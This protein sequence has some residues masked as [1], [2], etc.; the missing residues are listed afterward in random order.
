[1]GKKGGRAG[2]GVPKPRSDEARRRMLARRLIRAAD[3][4]GTIQA[5]AMVPLAP[6]RPDLHAAT[7][8]R[9]A[10]TALGVARETQD[11]TGVEW[12]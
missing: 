2:K 7:T 5:A 8:L 12:R 6:G 10:A 4:G 9:A 11:L 1:M 3:Q